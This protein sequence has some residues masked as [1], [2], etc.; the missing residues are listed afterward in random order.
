MKRRHLLLASATL[1]APRL[2]LGQGARVLKFI[3]QSDLAVFDPVWGSSYVTRNHG[4]MVYDTL[5]GLDDQYRVQPQMAAGHEVAADG[6]AWTITLRHGLR[7]HDGEP[8]RAADCVAS[9]TRWWRRDGFGQALAAATDAVEAL[10]DQRLRFRLRRPFPLL[11]HA[12]GKPGSPVCVMMPARVA[13]TSP[14]EQIR[15]YTGSGPFRLKLDER[16]PGARLVYERFAGYQPR[17]AGT[18]SFTAGPKRAFFDRVEW[19]VMPDPSTAAAALQAGEMDWWENPQADLLPLLERDRRL[20]VPPPDPAGYMAVM[21]CNHLHAPFDNPAIRRAVLPAV[22]QADFMRAVAGDGENRWRD[23]VGFFCPGTPMASEAGMQALVGPRDIAAARRALAEAGYKGEKVV[24]LSPGD[25]PSLKGLAE[26]GGDMLKRIGFN[27]DY[28][29]MDWG[30]MLQRLAKQE[31]ADQ[32]GWSVFFTFWSGLDQLNPAVHAMLR[33]NGRDAPSRG[34]P[35]SP[36]L[37]AL[38]DQWLAAADEA[39]QR[40]LAERMQAQAFADLP[41]VPLGQMLARTAHRR[42]LL[43]VLQGFAIFWNARKG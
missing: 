9:I 14:F 26:V 18:P 34:W 42:D 25:F 5:Y 21:R 12:L 27:V 11:L 15:D 28:Q 20:V 16:V 39:T 43:D 2:A 33:G 40:T 17:E 32:G 36:A 19:H 37:E 8:V 22:V 31:P 10:D 4:M 6:L 7:W 38:R 23:G 41:Y 3:P 30:T 29:S 35:S 24:V 13:A 1:A